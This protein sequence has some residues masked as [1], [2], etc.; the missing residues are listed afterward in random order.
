M[1]VRTLCLLFGSSPFSSLLLFHAVT[2]LRVCG[3]GPTTGSISTCRIPCLHPPP[4]NPFGL[5]PFPFPIYPVIPATVFV[6]P[7]PADFVP[8]FRLCHGLRL[9]GASGFF[10]LLPHHHFYLTA[11][12]YIQLLPY[13]VLPFLRIITGL[14]TVRWVDDPLRD[15]VRYYRATTPAFLPRIVV[16]CFA[17]LGSCA[18]CLL[19]TVPFSPLRCRHH[20]Q[21]LPAGDG[22]FL[23]RF[24]YACVLRIPRFACP[25]CTRSDVAF[26]VLL[27]PQNIPLLPNTVLRLYLFA[28]NGLP[29]Y[30]HHL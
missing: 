23:R 6:W 11:P 25:I 21:V 28:R 24:P 9:C 27:L 22:G 1:P 20:T 17:Q 2:I 10:L 26:L 30:H 13:V 5:I 3:V 4:Q 14:R 19:F 16:V 7:L 29:C 15:S 12:P 8:Y 18:C